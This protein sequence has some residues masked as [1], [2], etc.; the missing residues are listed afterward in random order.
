[1][2]LHNLKCNSALGATE[3]GRTAAPALAS[4]F[5]DSFEVR[6][7]S[8]REGRESYVDWWRGLASRKNSTPKANQQHKRK[9]GFCSRFDP[10]ERRGRQNYLVASTQSRVVRQFLRSGGK[11][12][13]ENGSLHAW[14]VRREPWKI[15]WEGG[16]RG[17]S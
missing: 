8:I 15:P 10:I 11:S 1:M 7:D 17:S 4:L 2:L 6:V 5:V 9:L 14:T 13:S 12:A 16:D 3:S